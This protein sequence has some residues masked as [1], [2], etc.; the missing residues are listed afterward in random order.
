MESY[1]DDIWECG[2]SQQAW[3]SGVVELRPGS[4][5]H[6]ENIQDV[7]NWQLAPPGTVEVFISVML[8]IW[9]SSLCHSVTTVIEKGPIFIF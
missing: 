8:L 9:L 7:H 3:I 6:P 1:S 5:F 2:L 4:S